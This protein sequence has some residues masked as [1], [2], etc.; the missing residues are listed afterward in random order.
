MA[1]R[2][3][4]YTEQFTIRVTPEQKQASE[5]LAQKSGIELMDWI[6]FAI[7]EKIK[8]DSETYEPPTWRGDIDDITHLLTL[9]DDPRVREKII[10]ITARGWGE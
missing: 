6:R 2:E 3:R 5:N 10:L 4:K 9:L 8:R 7:N 1:T